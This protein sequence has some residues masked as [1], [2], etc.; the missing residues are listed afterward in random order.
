MRIFTMCEE[1]Q[2]E[3]DDPSNRRFHAQPNACPH[4][5]PH[6]ELWD[7]EGVKLAT[8]REAMVG[9]ARAVHRGEIVAVKGLGGFHLV[10]DAASEKAVVRLRERK[11]REEKPLALMYPSL[12]LVKAH[13]E[14]SHLEEL[15][16]LSPASP[17]VLLRR[18]SDVVS[19]IVRAVAPGNP[20]LGVML[21]YTPLHHLLMA[22]IDRPV[23][24]TSGNLSDEP[25]CTD[26]REA[27]ERLGGIADLFLV[28]NRP[29]SRHVDDSIVRMILDREQV[30]RRARGYAPLPIQL[31]EKTAPTLAVGAHLKN[32]VAL[33]VDEQVFVSQ[34]IGDLETDAAY[35]AF[36]KVIES[37][38]RLYD[39]RPGAVIC[40]MHPDY[41]STHYAGRLGVPVRKVQ[42]HVAHVLA[43][44]IENDL[45]P[46]VLGVSWDGTG[47]G[48]DGTVWGGE[49]FRVTEDSVERVAH[50]RLF[51][52]P[53]G[54]KAIK[55]PRRSALGLIYELAGGDIS[56]EPESPVLGTFTDEERLLLRQ[57]VDRS[58]NSPRTS[59]AGRLFDGVAS[60]VGLRHFNR[61]EGQAAME[62]EYQVSNVE[63]LEQYNLG[64]RKGPNGTSAIVIDWEPMI[65]QIVA[66]VQ[67]GHS[68]NLIAAKFHNT[69]AEAVV[70]IAEE[71]ALTNVVLTGGCFQNKYLCEQAITRLQ[72]VGL[73]PYWHQR[74]SPNDG[75]IALGQ[76]VA[77]TRPV[78]SYIIEEQA[79]TGSDE[80]Q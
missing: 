59:S 36:E 51:P 17:I 18:R 45:V 30:L 53:G 60:L 57:M 4:C 75:G 54:E 27:L 23:I 25:I 38:E 61:F 15:S 24:A 73:E 65:R 80:K 16:L 47:Y 74:I 52:L 34:H 11:H 10:T 2:A 62:L 26:E 6:L 44:M 1:C 29:I 39:T 7:P 50:L 67:T 22:E 63:M 9:T 71:T 43:C 66:D 12:D 72:A 14:V 31:T 35:D 19:P 42:H 76:I 33:A 58:V 56:R 28:H 3:Y 68:T 69:L 20:Y 5:G 48:T 64:L 40:D 49:F 32:T 46:P 70:T 78:S 13:C 37:L 79:T 41:L 21:P 8:H 77:A 55:E